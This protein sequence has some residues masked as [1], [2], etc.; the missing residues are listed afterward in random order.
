MKTP[1]FQRIGE[2]FPLKKE[3]YS[4]KHVERITATAVPNLTVGTHFMIQMLTTGP[5]KNVHS[6]QSQS[7]PWSSSHHI[8]LCVQIMFN[9]L[10]TW[11]LGWII[12]LHWFFYTQSSPSYRGC[13]SHIKLQRMF[14]QEGR[15]KS[16][17]EA[18]Q[19][20]PV[21]EKG[22][23]LLGHSYSLKSGKDLSAALVSKSILIHWVN[24]DNS[25]RL[26]LSFLITSAVGADILIR[27]FL[28]LP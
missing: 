5:C 6:V 3:P 22:F 12:V 2:E 19:I 1:H 27:V 10:P 7:T 17:L 9:L 4:F 24:Q 26:E 8:Q 23:F 21:M 15:N 13:P 14:Y 25:K 11:G 18:D 28:S 16:L 20:L